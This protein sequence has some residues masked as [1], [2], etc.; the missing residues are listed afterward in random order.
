M[1]KIILSIINHYW[2][3]K[4]IIKTYI[5]VTFPFVSL[6]SFLRSLRLNQSENNVKLES[7]KNKHEDQRCF[8]VGNGPSL[9]ASDLDKIMNQYSIGFNK[10][11][12]MFKKTQWRPTYSIIADQ[13]IFMSIKDEI[14]QKGFVDIFIGANCK[15]YGRV[16]D[17]TYFYTR[18]SFN[19]TNPRFSDDALKFFY[20]GYTV[21]YFGLQMAIYM[22]FKEI[23]LL[24]VDCNYS[25]DFDN[26]GNIRVDKSIKNYFTDSY[27]KD[28][29]VKNTEYMKNAYRSAEKYANANGI[30]I[31]NATRGGELEEFKRIEFDEIDFI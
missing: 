31:Y 28:I 25:K 13:N 24:G 22:G 27:I 17:V 16:N 2:V 18:P 15:K 21:A 26:K 12:L 19:T 20:D 10:I 23:Y 11:Y 4:I 14:H 9:K 6:N 1:K 5:I 7:Y 29:R 3:H 30:K 8:I